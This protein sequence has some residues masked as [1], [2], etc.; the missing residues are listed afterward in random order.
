MGAEELTPE[1]R[2]I[3]PPVHFRRKKKTSS[4]WYPHEFLSQP[5]KRESFMSPAAMPID[6]CLLVSDTGCMV[7]IVA[8]V[9]AKHISR[10]CTILPSI[11]LD[12]IIV[13]AIRRSARQILMLVEMGSCRAV[14]VA[15]HTSDILDW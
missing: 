1:C 13:L 8:E 2:P 3:G 7:S 11:Y 5:G 4:P 12:L 6:I 15:R 14:N 9:S 10:K